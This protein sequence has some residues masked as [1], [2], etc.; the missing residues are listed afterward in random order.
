MLQL[1]YLIIM[2]I[3]H[4]LYQFLPTSKNLE[5][6]IVEVRLLDLEYNA[7]KTFFF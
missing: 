6:I 1:L 3:N 4:H 5:Q 2:G 7:N